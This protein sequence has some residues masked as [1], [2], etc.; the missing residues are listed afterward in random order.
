MWSTGH[1]AT[2]AWGQRIVT[3]I[4]ILKPFGDITNHVAQPM[5]G[6]TFGL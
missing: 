6:V 2:V 3:A 1:C 4:I 5:S